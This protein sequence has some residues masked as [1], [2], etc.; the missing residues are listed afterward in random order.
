M[1]IACAIHGIAC[2][3]EAPYD[4]PQVV[5][6]RGNK[7]GDSPGMPLMRRGRSSSHNKR[8]NYGEYND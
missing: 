4:V 7:E 3:A 2:A 8:G 1:F 6:I 5:E